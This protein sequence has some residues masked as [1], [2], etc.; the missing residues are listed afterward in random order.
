[1]FCSACYNLGRPD[2]NTHFLRKSKD[3]KSEIVCQVILSSICRYCK[4]KGHTKS[5]CPTLNLKNYSPSISQSRHQLRDYKESNGWETVKNNPRSMQK[6]IMNN[7]SYISSNPFDCIA[8]DPPP[9]S[10][11]SSSPTSSPS[12]SPTSFTLDGQPLPHI[13]WGANISSWAD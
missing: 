2:Y 8:H 13:V 11:P 4:K 12:S 9:T 7:I 5:H 10:S 6:N 1:M 3:P